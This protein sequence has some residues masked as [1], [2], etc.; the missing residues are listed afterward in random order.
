MQTRFCRDP[1]G[2]HNPN[3]EFCNKKTK[4]EVKFPRQGRFCLGV[5][6]VDRGNNP[7]G[8][9]LDLI[10]Y[11]CQNIV[12]IKVFKKMVMKIIATVKKLPRDTNGWFVDLRE[13]CALYFN[14]PVQETRTCGAKRRG[15]R[16]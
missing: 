2:S 9:Q 16:I 4:C 13:S 11:T 1:D 3:S 8:E 10:D 12:R 5:G 15:L 6:I 14:N 7:K